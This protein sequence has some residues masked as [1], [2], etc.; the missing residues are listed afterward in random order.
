MSQRLIKLS[1]FLI[2]VLSG[3]A[4]WA[5]IEQIQAS[6][7]PGEPGCFGT[8]RGYRVNPPG[9]CGCYTNAEGCT[10]TCGGGPSGCTVYRY[11]CHANTPRG[12]GTTRLISCSPTSCGCDPAPITY[13]N[14]TYTCGNGVRNT[15]C[16]EQ[17]DDGNNV[18]G[19]GCYQCR[20][21]YCGDG[22]INDG[23]PGGAGEECDNGAANSNAPNATCRASGSFAC[24]LR[25][26]GD[27]IV[28]DAFGEQCDDGNRN[29]LDSCNTACQFTATADPWLATSEGNIYAAQG[30]SGFEQQ[31]VASLNPPIDFA[32]YGYDYN[33]VVNLAEYLVSSGNATL[34]GTNYISENNYRALNYTDDSLT[35]YRA[36]GAQTNWFDFLRQIVVR[37]RGSN[38]SV[39]NTASITSANIN[40]ALGATAGALYV[41]ERT[42]D[43]TI[44]NTAAPATV[45][46]NIK[47]IIFVTGNLTVVPD[48]RTSS[49]T[50]GCI[51]IVRGN[52]IVDVGQRK[53][54]ASSLVTDPTQY[55]IVEGM[56]FTNGT[57]TTQLD[58][59]GVNEKWDGIYVKG[60]V[61]SKSTSL[62]RDLRSFSNVSQPAE[63]YV[64]DPRYM[65]I[66]ELRI[67]ID[68]KKLTLKEF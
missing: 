41:G 35:A 29:E 18:Q 46:C 30:Y 50:N 26:C 42:G 45:T 59:F 10:G 5:G 44:G 21:E 33:K 60:S 65:A 17:C 28:D 6:C 40:T 53:N 38:P 22:I 62:N 57:F 51:F 13:Y 31:N 68:F 43:L 20:N 24:R 11:Y 64:Y 55:D 58:Q 1:L 61:V 48:L 39:I 34:P 8:C 19:D 15:L 25:M 12:N 3:V 27:G 66:P 67:V 2:L 14:T 37:N 47:G 36:F 52:I 23:P 7:C 16:Y 63:V 54:P 56:F 4:L 9:G 49:F 32:G